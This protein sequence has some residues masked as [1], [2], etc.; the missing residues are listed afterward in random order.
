MIL[1]HT[2]ALVRTGKRRIDIT[3]V[4]R[5]AIGCFEYFN[6][7]NH[8]DMTFSQSA[9]VRCASTGCHV[10]LREL[11]LN[12][13]PSGYEPDELPSCSIPRSLDRLICG[14]HIVYHKIRATSRA[15]PNFRPFA[16]QKSS[17]EEKSHQYAIDFYRIAHVLRTPFRLRC[18]R[19]CTNSRS[20]LYS[21]SA[22]QTS[23]ARNA[24]WYA[25][26]PQNSRSS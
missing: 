13:R 1:P 26:P 16:Q 20:E 10:W 7:Q 23:T 2:V 9:S 22:A 25:I 24:N 3:P 11:D 18:F 12:Q 8:Q 14:T 17:L 6:F 19:E 15:K 5:S 4:N 21:R